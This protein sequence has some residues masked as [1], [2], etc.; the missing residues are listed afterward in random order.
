MGLTLVLVTGAGFFVETL[1]HLRK[2]SLGF[3]TERVLDAQ[4]MPLPGGYAHG[5]SAAPYYHELLNRMQ[6]LPGVEAVSLSHFSPLFTLPF[7]EKIRSARSADAPAVQAPA[8]DVSDGFLA[9]LR[10]PLL[11]GRDFQ[12]MDSPQSQK[13]AIVSESLAKRLFPDGAALGQHISVG[14][15]KDTQ[16]LEIVGVA[17]D[18]RLMDPH[19]RDGSFVYLDS[20]QHPDYEKWGDLQL[21][22]R[23]DPEALIGA[24]RRELRNAGHEYPLHVRTIAEQRDNALLQ[25]NLLAALGTAF[26]VLALTLAGVGLFGLLSL[27]VTLRRSEIAIRVALGAGRGD[28]SWM[29]IRESLVLAGAGLLVGLPLSFAAVRALSG[30]LYGVGQWPVAPLVLAI[31]LLLSVAGIAAV[32]PVGRATSVDPMVALRCE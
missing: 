7:Y 6:S 20:W 15:Q 25:E 24:V 8:E 12:R 26:G 27:L 32:I 23:G 28:V 18:A 9:T 10:I 13:T 22:Y 14:A 3:Q 5:F 11:R 19:T 21:R 4:L 29:V 31:A 2:E 30:L 1:R 17:A 16:D